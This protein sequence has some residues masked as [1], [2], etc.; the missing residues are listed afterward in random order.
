MI[1]G[2]IIKDESLLIAKADFVSNPISIPP[3]GK[4]NIQN[5][6]LFL[7]LFTWVEYIN[8]LSEH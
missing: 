1:K 3:T 5:M 4:K 7:I 8:R 2:K 6:M